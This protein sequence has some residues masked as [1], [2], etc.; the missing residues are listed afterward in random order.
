MIIDKKNKTKL[1]RHPASAEYMHTWFEFHK[2]TWGYRFYSKENGEHVWDYMIFYK[3]YPN[4]KKL[5]AIAE[6]RDTELYSRVDAAGFYNGNSTVK[7]NL[8]ISTFTPEES[9]QTTLF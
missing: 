3:F 2:R 5:F 8:N 4:E 9:T 7:Y 6:G 1:P